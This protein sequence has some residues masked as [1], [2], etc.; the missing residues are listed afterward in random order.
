MP[1]QLKFEINFSEDITILYKLVDD[2]I[3]NEW[4]ELISAHSIND[5]CPIN[6]YI[7]YADDVLISSR[8]DRLSE[9]AELINQT[10]PNRVIVHDITSKTWKV[11]LQ[12]M[13]IHFPELKNNEF[14]S[15]L[16]PV[17]TEYNDIIHWLESI[18]CNIWATSP[19]PSKSSTFRITLDF[20]KTT[21]KFLPIPED[22]FKLFDPLLNFGYLLLQYTH[23]GKNAHEMFMTRDFECPK[24]QFI[25]Q[26]DFNASVRMYFLDNF[27][28]Q[29]RVTAFNES[30]QKF[31]NDKGGFDFW[32]ID[33]ND[34]KIAFGYLKIGEIESISGID[35][36]NT[37]AE[38]NSFRDKL[39]KQTVLSWNIRKGA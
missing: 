22:S 26:R 25:P 38:M 21:S 7:G 27:V 31:Y 32:G 20:N 18:L 24:H 34:P 16:W 6:H 10:V 15:H 19:L 30:W 5:C 8:I 29:D 17:L 4:A 28:P 39:V 9:L 13:H 11:N 1:T 37:L 23:V 35:I 36:P 12:K 2:I 14:Y 3:V 33:I